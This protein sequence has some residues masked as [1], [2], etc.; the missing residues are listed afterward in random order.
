M[1]KKINLQKKERIRYLRSRGYSIPEISNELS[2]SKTT[3]LRYI[4]DTE[5][6]PEFLSDWAEKRGGSRKRKLLKESQIYEETK[7]YLSNLSSKEKLLL[8]SAL[9][10]AEG[11]KKDLL[12]INS[13]PN[14]IKVFLEGLR[15]YFDI[16]ED[17]I[18]ANI[19]I[20]LGT[21]EERCLD[22]WSELTR[23]PRCN[24]QRTEIIAAGK[25][26]GKLQYGMCR[27]RISKGGDIL[28][29]LLSVNKVVHEIL[30]KSDIAKI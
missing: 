15:E 24:F 22:Y 3:V 9:Y 14:L 13:D 1:S 25:K 17:R 10:W 6:L 2:V 5:I 23:I 4:K 11:N 7:L 28:K 30:T 16:H 12:F 18:K 8:I 19:R 26:K 29:K 21:D 27:I 20:H